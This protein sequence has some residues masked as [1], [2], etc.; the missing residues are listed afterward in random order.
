MYHTP[1]PSQSVFLLDQL[2]R[3][4]NGTAASRLYLMLQAHTDGGTAVSMAT[5]SQVRRSSYQDLLQCLFKFSEGVRAVT[6]WF[7]RLSHPNACRMPLCLSVVTIFVKI[8]ILLTRQQQI[9][10]LLLEFFCLVIEIFFRS[11]L[12][13]NNK[14]SWMRFLLE[15]RADWVLVLPPE[16]CRWWNWSIQVLSVHIINLW[17]EVFLMG[18]W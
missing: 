9:L 6:H 5:V 4:H 2:G 1:Q 3:C 12:E 10:Y 7:S 8:L 14:D 11:A 18:V 17:W 13:P 16:A 15:N